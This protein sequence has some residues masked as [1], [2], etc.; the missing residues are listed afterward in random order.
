MPISGKRARTLA[1]AFGV[2][3]AVEVLLLVAASVLDQRWIE[4]GALIMGTI[5]VPIL[6]IVLFAAGLRVLKM[7]KLTRSIG[8]DNTVGDPVAGESQ[9]ERFIQEKTGMSSYLGILPINDQPNSK[10]AN[11]SKVRFVPTASGRWLGV[12]VLLFGASVGLWLAQRA[13]DQSPGDVGDKHQVGVARVA[14]GAGLGALIASPISLILM[15]A[16]SRRKEENDTRR[17][18]PETA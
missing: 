11:V 8:D 10:I 2:A 6:M 16:L 7:R 13:H 12:M 4:L 18:R 1:I 14:V 3:L 17:D 15:S 5:Q 9:L